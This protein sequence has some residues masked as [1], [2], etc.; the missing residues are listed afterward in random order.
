MSET[1]GW[2]AP[3]WDQSRP[4]EAA[5]HPG[6]G[7]P[8]ADPQGA[9]TGWVS[10][11]WGTPAPPE[12]KPGVVPLRPLGLGELLDAAV[13]TIRRHPRVTLGYSA[14]FA[15]LGQGITIAAAAANGRFGGRLP[16][17]GSP[18][19]SLSTLTSSS[20]I[21]AMLAASF[22][23]LV[24]TG[25]IAVVI[26]EAVLGREVSAGQVWHRVRPL[27]LPLLVLSALVAVVPFV[28]LPLLLAPGI[29]LWGAWALAV[30]A[31]VLERGSVRDALRRSWQ[32]ARPDWGRVWL[33][34]TLSW[35]LAS[36]L[37]SL[38][39][40]AFGAVALVSVFRAA[41]AGS[42][43]ATISPLGLTL[44]AIGSVLASTLTAPFQAGVLSLLYIDRRM[45]AE[46]LDVALQGSVRG[47]PAAGT[48]APDAL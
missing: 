23:D 4:G 13:T 6:A 41:V 10:Q 21:L 46:G 26:G 24:L 19:S 9:N 34:R 22:F 7:V 30:P 38:I 18:F 15:L 45:R 5:E 33:I 35:L 27:L 3:N 29:F 47:V 36:V 16:T 12:V 8:A 44:L 1:P 32:L 43:A 28:G 2:A 31:L 48:A 37:G 11:P 40:A 39:G 25:F 17:R 20:T 14:L 42:A